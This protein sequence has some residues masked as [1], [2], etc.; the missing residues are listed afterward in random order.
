VCADAIGA[1]ADLAK[2]NGRRP[3]CV[4][5]RSTEC[6][7]R[8]LEDDAFFESHVL[9]EQNSECIQAI[10]VRRIC[11]NAGSF[12]HKHGVLGSHRVGMCVETFVF[13]AQTRQQ[14]GLLLFDV[15]AAVR[16]PIGKKIAPRRLCGART[17]IAF[18]QPADLTTLQEEQLMVA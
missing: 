17:M 3:K 1:A 16:L 6:G 11:V 12:A 9:L 13:A 15:H 18:L 5:V 8:R 7:L 10:Y 4:Q 2:R 14:H